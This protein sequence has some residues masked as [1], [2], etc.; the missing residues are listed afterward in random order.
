MLY[1]LYRSNCTT[2][3]HLH[4]SYYNRLFL[5]QTEIIGTEGLPTTPLY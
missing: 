3:K 1:E 2:R 5:E 4:H